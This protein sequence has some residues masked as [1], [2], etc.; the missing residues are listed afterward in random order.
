MAEKITEIEG[1]E[2]LV[3]KSQLSGIVSDIVKLLHDED[4]NV[5]NAY[6]ALVGELGN[7][8]EQ[9]GETPA[10]PHTVKS[11]VEAA[12]A[13]VN[14]A[15][16]ELAGKV[17]D[18]ADAIALLNKNKDNVGS[19]D[20]KIAEAFKT[21]TTELGEADVIDS[22]KDLLDYAATHKGEY[23]DLIALVG[24]LP[25]DAGVTTIVAYAEKLAAAAQK[26][27][28][29]RIKAIEDD[30]LKAADKTEL[31]TAIG[32]EKTRA[33][34][35]EKDITDRLDIIEGEETQAGSIKKAL[36]DAK[37]YAD[38]LAGNYDEAGAA[39]AVQGETTL[40]VADLAAALNGA[41]MTDTDVAEIKALIK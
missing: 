2:K 13:G 17:Q 3:V 5:T 20:Y 26:E 34:G 40:T 6:K 23:T 36:K 10:V 29:D 15:A 32:D 1:F 16:E 30:Y 33:E 8:S 9:D 31:S 38:G 4:T 7:K 12:I 35:A 22:F 39:A 14:G 19:V 21:F 24:S 28:D 37:D 27:A 11:F 41:V 25:A 18:N